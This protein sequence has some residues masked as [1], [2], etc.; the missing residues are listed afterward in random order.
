MDGHEPDLKHVGPSASASTGLWDLEWKRTH[1][2]YEVRPPVGFQS[3][4]QVIAE[5]DMN[6]KTG[7]ERRT[8]TTD[9]PEPAEEY[10]PSDDGKEGQE[11]R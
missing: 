11:P 1:I 5:P 10:R 3:P 4:A 7:E 8:N 6:A 9:S 2:K